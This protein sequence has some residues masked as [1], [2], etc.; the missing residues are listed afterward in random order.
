MKK[1]EQKNEELKE[2]LETFEESSVSESGL[3]FEQNFKLHCP[4]RSSPKCS[5]TLLIGT[6]LF[7]IPCCFELKTITLG[8]ALQSFTIGSVELPP[9]RNIL[10]FSC[11]FQMARLQLYLG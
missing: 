9:F 1:T 8:Y 11:Q 5:W 2:K 6:W 3:N 10:R 4:L 7:W